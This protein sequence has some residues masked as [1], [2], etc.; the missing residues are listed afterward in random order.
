MSILHIKA[1]KK[2]LHIFSSHFNTPQNTSR[3]TILYSKPIQQNMHMIQNS[4]SEGI[5]SKYETFYNH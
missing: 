1:L 2:N 5:S 3:W 4:I